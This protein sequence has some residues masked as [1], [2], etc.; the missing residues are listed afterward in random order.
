ME[1]EGQVYCQIISPQLNIGGHIS[2]RASNG[3]T[4]ILI[5]NRE[6]TKVEHCILKVLLC[7][8]KIFK[9]SL[10]L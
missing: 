2:R 9:F 3:N 5:N 8:H 4:K 6:I 1:Q 10:R 7:L